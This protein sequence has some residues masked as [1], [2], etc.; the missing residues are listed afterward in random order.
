MAKGED[1]PVLLAS[2]LIVSAAVYAYINSLTHTFTLL[3]LLYGATALTGGLAHRFTGEK[4]LLNILV[5]LFGIMLLLAW[6]TI[7]LLLMIEVITIPTAEILHAFWKG[8][9][10]L[11]VLGVIYIIGEIQ[12]MN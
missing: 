2:I 6:S 10:F 8:F 1:L 11:I 4:G 12:L 3:M 5:G 9:T 7:D